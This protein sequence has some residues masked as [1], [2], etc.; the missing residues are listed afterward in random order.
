MKRQLSNPE[1]FVRI[2]E[3]SRG[4]KNAM[5]SS[6]PNFRMREFLSSYGFLGSR[7]NA[8]KVLSIV[9]NK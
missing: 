1:E 4:F 3:N 8:N 5:N 7:E 6:N 9:S 2:Q